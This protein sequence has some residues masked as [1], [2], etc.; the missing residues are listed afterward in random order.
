M[1]FDREKRLYIQFKPLETRRGKTIFLA[2]NTE[3]T[4]FLIIFS[5]C[6][7]CALW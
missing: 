1:E 6:S 7:L 2:E 4:E 5:Q 3:H